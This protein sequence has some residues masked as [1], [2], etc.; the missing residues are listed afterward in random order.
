M[1]KQYCF[2]DDQSGKGFMVCCEKCDRWYHGRCIKIT[3]KLADSI[4]MYYCEKCLKKFSN[5]EIRFKAGVE[6]FPIPKVLFSKKEP[7]DD[8]RKDKKVLEKRQP[9]SLIPQSKQTNIDTPRTKRRAG[10]K[11]KAKIQSARQCGNPDCIN[12]CRIDS[13]YCSDECGYEFNKK[14]YNTFYIPKYKELEA[15]HSQ[16]R[17]EKM[18]ELDKLEKEKISVEQLIKSLKFEKEELEDNIRAIKSEATNHMNLK[19][20]TK[21][22]SD[23]EKPED[24]N[25]EYDDAPGNDLTGDSSKTFC[26]TCGLTVQPPKTLNHWS[27]CHRKAE[28]QYAFTADAIVSHAGQCKDDEDPRLYCHH[29]DK[30]TKR[31][32]MNME[33]ACPQHSNWH[34]D[35]NEVCGCPLN[36]MQK[37]VLDGNYCTELKKNCNQHYHWDKFRLTQLNM[38]RIQAFNRLDAIN[39]RIRTASNN[40]ADT[41]GG[42]VGV[43][44]HNTINHTSSNNEENVNESMVVDVE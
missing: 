24:T 4:D 23:K 1:S 38:Q 13:K 40:L 17:L 5:L 29:Y 44:L 22:N 35:K 26:F 42:V 21:S 7:I 8:K 31:Y 28:T 34:G 16:A 18:K 37:L 14:R 9:I 27:L 43:M 6:P 2:C 30:K 25:A 10:Q 20:A 33:S 19:D 32:C 41:Y 3:K 12:E 11:T 36:I 39:D 15:N